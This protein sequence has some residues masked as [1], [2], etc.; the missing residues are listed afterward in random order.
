MYHPGTPCITQV[1]CC[2]IFS[3]TNTF[4]PG[5][6]GGEGGV[7]KSNSP[8]SVVCANIVGFFQKGFNVFNVIV[9]YGMRRHQIFMGNWVSVISSPTIKWSFRVLMVSFTVFTWWMCGVANC[10]LISSCLLYLL[11]LA[12]A[13]LSIQFTYG[14]Y[15]LFVGCST[16]LVYASIMWIPDLLLR[17]Y[18]KIAL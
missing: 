17:C 3:C 2:C 18:S 9:V 11:R 4:I 10:Y 14:Q 6:A 12:D 8:S 1:L 5:G 7:L 16:F 15:S 13:S